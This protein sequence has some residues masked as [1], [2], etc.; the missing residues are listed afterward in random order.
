MMNSKFLQ[1]MLAM[2][3]ITPDV[4]EWADQFPTPAIQS[5]AIHRYRDEIAGL[6]NQIKAELL[7]PQIPT[8]APLGAGAPRRHVWAEIIVNGGLA[9]GIIAA[10]HFWAPGPEQLIRRFGPYRSAAI[11]EWDPQRSGHDPATPSA[12][13]L[14]FYW[15]PLGF[16]HGVNLYMRPR[17][18]PEARYRKLNDE[19]LMGGHVVYHPTIDDPND[20]EFVLTSVNPWGGESFYSTPLWFDLWDLK[21]AP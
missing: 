18:S 21:P 20:A 3:K 7:K 16:W 5:V 9:L 19:P 10:F 13:G 11:P 17:F 1:N 14:T 4:A 15:E 2:K 6:K 8:P 12:S